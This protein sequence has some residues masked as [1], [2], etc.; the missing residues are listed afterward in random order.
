MV[1]LKLSPLFVGLKLG[2]LVGC[3]GFNVGGAIVGFVGGVG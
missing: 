2:L 3:V 1:G